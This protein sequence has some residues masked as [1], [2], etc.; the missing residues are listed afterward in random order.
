MRTL[1]KQNKI[2]AQCNITNLIDTEPGKQ[3][4][5]EG[6][7]ADIRQALGE[8][9]GQF[10]E[11]S[12]S[13][14][15][16]GLRMVRIASSGEV[17]QVPVQW[18]NVHFSNDEGRHVSLVFSM[19]AANAEIFGAADSQ[20]AGAFEFQAIPKA[21]NPAPKTETNDNKPAQVSQNNSGKQT[22]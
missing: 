20:I 4:T 5:L 7:Q 14:T 11:S 2:V 19:D 8:S 10:L 12:E 17:E 1:I 16:S 18:I 21:E 9:F 15:E 13:L 22:K 3:L 6:Y